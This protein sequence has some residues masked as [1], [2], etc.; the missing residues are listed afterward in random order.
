MRYTLLGR[1]GLRVSELCLGTMTFGGAWGWG[2]T[3]DVCK[4]QLDMFFG[5]GG[6]FIDTANRY[7]DGESEEILGRL[8]KGRRD[9]V[10]LATKYTMSTREG[11]PNAGGNARKNM[12]QSVAASLERLRTDYIDLYWVHAWDMLT[13]IDEVMRALDD[14]V[15]S[16]R[17]L[18]VGVSDYPAWKVSE[19]NTLADLRGWSPF[20]GLQ[21]EYSLAMR[22]VER[23]LIPMARD[24]R[25]GVTPWS[26]LAGGLLTGKYTREDLAAKD[27][28][29][30]G[31]R[32]K[33]RRQ[34]VSSRLTENKLAIAEAV[35]AAG[36]E[37]GRSPA[38]VALRWV[39]DQPGVTSTI[40]GARTTEQLED[41]LGSLDFQLDSEHNARLNKVSQVELGFPHDMLM[42]PRV[43]QFIHGGVE[44]D[45]H[46]S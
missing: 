14:L 34:L 1:S 6:N 3:E 40:L 5:R 18:Y 19:A 41:N 13:P 25:I 9:E 15:R 12:M 35:A 32:P 8:L 29:T 45:S 44:I 21:I 23:E 27:G 16:G 17:V 37:L 4:K 38:Q 2:A 7:T 30:S 10:V 24:L 28:L 42:S 11:D 43:K 36:R 31:E 26:P 46:E 20:V 33:D 39:L 22:D